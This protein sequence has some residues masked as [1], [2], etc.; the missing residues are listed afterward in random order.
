[1]KVVGPLIPGGE[2]EQKAAAAGEFLNLRRESEQ[3]TKT[4]SEMWSRE[5]HRF[6]HVRHRRRTKYAGRVLLAAEIRAQRQPAHAM[7]DDIHYIH[8]LPVFIAQA[9]EEIA[10]R[11]TEILDGRRGS[12]ATSVKEKAHF[13]VGLQYLVGGAEGARQ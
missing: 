13:A 7:S 12:E 2:V 4:G 3:Q 5:E 1:M 11:R 9:R 10:E 8:R 6:T